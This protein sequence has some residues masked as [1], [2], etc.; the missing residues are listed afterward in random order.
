MESE[1]S[2]HALV[3]S[4]TE[5]L[6]SFDSTENTKPGVP[7]TDQH[8]EG[9]FS[10]TEN[11]VAGDNA[12]FANGQPVKTADS[13]HVLCEFADDGTGLFPACNTGAG[14]SVNSEDVWLSLMSCVTPD[15]HP[16]TG[17][18]PASPVLTVGEDSSEA[19]ADRKADYIK[20]SISGPGVIV[21]NNVREATNTTLLE[22]EDTSC[23]TLTVRNQNEDAD[24]L[25]ASAPAADHL[26]TDEHDS[27]K[28]SSDIFSDFTG[29]SNVVTEHINKT[30]THMDET[31]SENLH[32]D[33][34][35]QCMQPFKPF[36]DADEFNQQFS[37]CEFNQQF[38]GSDHVWRPVSSTHQVFDQQTLESNNDVSL[39]KHDINASLPDVHTS[40][41]K[42]ELIA[43]FSDQLFSEVHPDVTV[44]SCDLIQ[45][46][47]NGAVAIEEI[48]VNSFNNFNHILC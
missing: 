30:Q 35:R 15:I 40:A 7:V 24:Q 18:S 39:K 48:Q 26:I 46:T 3:N 38:N 19:Y 9:S 4:S 43:T 13:E 23:K 16:V 22:L 36:P 6:I 45:P 42:Q 2:D 33:N 31:R 8:C 27:I 11:T 25:S 21:G 28:Q 34:K 32:D 37:D 5:F 47:M 29:F 20:H 10:V 14:E 12:V 41:I 1:N 44:P 17:E